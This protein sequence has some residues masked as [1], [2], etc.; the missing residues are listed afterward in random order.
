MLAISAIEY[1]FFGEQIVARIANWF[2]V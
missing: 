2:G 1:L